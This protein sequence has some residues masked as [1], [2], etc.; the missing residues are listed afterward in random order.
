VSVTNEAAFGDTSGPRQALAMAVFRAVENR[1]AVARAAT[2]GV[3]AFIDPHGR[4][5]SRVRGADGREVYVAG[6]L[7]WDLPL[8]TRT[9]FY[10]RN[11][12]VFAL[13]A[14]LSALG[15]LLWATRRRLP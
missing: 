9:T 6:S 1:V 11:G 7:V 4:V 3:S 10:T 15:L 5:V 8:A 13:L 14:S 2:T 12:D